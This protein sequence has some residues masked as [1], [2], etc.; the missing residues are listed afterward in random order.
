MFINFYRISLFKYGELD[1][2]IVCKMVT[3]SDSNFNGILARFFL[4][5]A[6]KRTQAY[7]FLIDFYIGNSMVLDGNSR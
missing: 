6:D 3:L 7:N 4:A 1:I 5:C 2:F